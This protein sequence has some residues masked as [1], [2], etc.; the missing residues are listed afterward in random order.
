M[1]SVVIFAA[2]L[3]TLFVDQTS[4]GA[5]EKS[6]H[7]STA[8][9]IRLVTQQG[10]AIAL[11]SNVLQSQ[12]TVLFDSIG[13]GSRCGAMSSGSGSS[14]TVRSV[15][16]GD[17]TSSAITIYYDAACAH[18]YIEATARIVKTSS[19]DVVSEVATYIGPTGAELGRLQLTEEAVMSTSTVGVHGTGTFSPRDGAPSVHL[20][21]ACTI[22]NS[23]A[24]VPP[25]FVCEGGIAQTFP[26][27]GV[28]LGSVTPITLRLKQAGAND[29]SVNFASSH[30]TMKRDKPGALS[31]G[32]TSNSQL[33]VTGG[34]TLVT[35]DVTSGTAGGFALFPP[36]PTGWTVTDRAKKV[37]F[38]ISVL[39]DATRQLE[40][41][42][43]STSGKKLAH[44]KVDRSGTG[45]ISYVGGAT[46]A[47]TSWLLSG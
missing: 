4:S 30:S 28:S 47:I 15:T 41:V 16:S 7:S 32:T 27:L 21:L 8:I 13:G 6:A 12:L 35:S 20:G 37:V 19:T 36:T 25:P 22:P 1:A 34:G 9:D 26:H 2:S 29:I 46:D 33:R 14:K 23:S 42:V 31:I 39:N 3:T 5:G 43:T 38:S 45:T 10:L 17:V 24:T 18:P 44:I 40:G 11:A